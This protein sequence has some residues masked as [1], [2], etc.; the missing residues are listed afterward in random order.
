VFAQ[1]PTDAKEGDTNKRYGTVVKSP[2]YITS[3]PLSYDKVLEAN[4]K[5]ADLLNQRI[6]QAK[7][8]PNIIVDMT[9]MTASAR[10]GALKAVEGAEDEYHKVAVVFN[11]EGAEDI[12]KKVA[13]KRAEQAKLDGKS[14]T[15]PPEAFDRMFKSFQK[16]TPD[17]GFDEVIS[18]D[19][20]ANLKKSL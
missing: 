3:A 7:G 11:F 2:S 5:V 17:E 4:N 13:A 19:N 9:N 20:I 6:K 8:E 1:V 12:I 18:Y 14:K 15:I 16:V 10:K